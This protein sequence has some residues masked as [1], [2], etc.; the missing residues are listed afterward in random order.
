M[1]KCAICGEQPIVSYKNGSWV[2]ECST[3]DCSAVPVAGDELEEAKGY[4]DAAQ[5]PGESKE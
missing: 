5:V 4:W 3:V 1:K 2:L